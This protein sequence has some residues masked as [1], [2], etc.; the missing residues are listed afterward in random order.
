[1]SKVI[2]L[3]LGVCLALAACESPEA[4]ATKAA[5]QNIGPKPEN[6]ELLI[7]DY[8][9]RYPR[10]GWWV[11]DRIHIVGGPKRGNTITRTSQ[12]FVTDIQPFWLVCAHLYRRSPET[13]TVEGKRVLFQIIHGVVVGAQAD[14]EW[15]GP[16][17]CEKWAW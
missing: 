15:S 3:V 5:E 16:T 14:S 12:G 11:P 4:L 17:Y 13:Q 8:Y 7:N 9:R 6:V 10:R 2:S 1:M